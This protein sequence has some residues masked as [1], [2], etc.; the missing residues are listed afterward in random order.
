MERLDTTQKWFSCTIDPPFAP[1]PVSDN[2]S[3]TLT[4]ELDLVVRGLDFVWSHW[5]IL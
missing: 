3:A 5:H 4:Q 1:S 2:S